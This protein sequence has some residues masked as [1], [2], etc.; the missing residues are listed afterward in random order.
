MYVV[1]RDGQ[2][3]PVMFEK[4][5]TRIT[6]LSYGLDSTFVDPIHV[7]QQ[8]CSGVYRGVTTV[9]LDELAAE[10]AAH[11]TSIH[12]DYGVLAA[13]LAVSNLHKQTDKAFSRTI[14]RLYRYVNP[15]TGLSGSLIAEDVYQFIMANA[16]E[17]NAAI[18]YNRGMYLQ[19]LYVY[20]VIHGYH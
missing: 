4:V 5:T 18:V 16:A 1:K 3:E 12:P 2:Q 10:T 15:E 17:L 9:E 8:V 14:D 7:A 13:R 11:L 6:R 19:Y 20:T